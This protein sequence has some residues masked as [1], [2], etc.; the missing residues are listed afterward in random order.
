MDSMGPLSR[1]RA[2]LTSGSSPRR[3]RG[4][5]GSRA[6]R[7]AARAGYGPD[8][9]AGPH[10]QRRLELAQ[11]AA[12]RRR[13]RAAREHR[14]RGPRRASGPRAAARGTRR[15]ARRRR[16]RPPRGPRRHE[17][18]RTGAPRPR[19]HRGAAGSHPAG[20]AAPARR[21]RRDG[22]R[23][24][25]ASGR[26][27]VACLDTAFHSHIPAA[28]ATYALPREWRERHSLR[29]FGFHGLSHAYASRRAAEL[30]GRRPEQL[31]V[32]SC[33]LGAGASLAAVDGGRSVDTTM[34]FTP[35]EGLVMATRSGSVDPGL[36]L[37]LLQHGGLGVE[38]VSDA[39]EH[40]SGLLALAGTADMR[41]VLAARPRRRRAGDLGEGRL[42]PSP[43]RP[44]RR[45][46][47]L[48]RRARRPRL[49]RRR[50]RAF[51]RDPDG[52]GARAPVPRAS[53]SIRRSTPRRDPT[54]T[55]R[56]RSPR[57]ARS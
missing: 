36:L 48:A 1:E 56:R 6:Q 9:H 11:A 33:H 10:R 53:R 5:H 23:V 54:P 37:W 14:A 20:A 28:A 32:V 7:A 38:E 41:E 50:R 13:R 30:L 26:P 47:R 34:G 19:G 35:V 24:R 2:R 42:P 22:R 25:R 15:H 39:L 51:Q 45:D 3:M 21:P 52:G 44:H 29:R 17:V 57:S 27:A 31:R 43:P 18:H 4:F 40:R 55:S 12:P 49:H 8:G 46:G 16:D